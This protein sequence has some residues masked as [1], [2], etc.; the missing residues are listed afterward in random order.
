MSKKDYYELLEIG[1]NASVEEIKKS[2]KRLA[3]KYH[4]DRNPNNKEAEEK[5][6]EIASA[7][8]VLSDSQKR[9]T[10]D[11]YGQESPFGSSQSFHSSGDFSDIFND[12]FSGGFNSTSR[13]K[14]NKNTSAGVPGSDLRYDLEITLEDS[15]KGI[16]APIHY[17]TNIKC[18]V[19]QGIG[20]EGAI[21]PVKCHACK[22]SGMTRA[23]QGFFTIERTCNVCYGEGEIIKNKCKKCDGNGRK[24]A[25]VNI[26]VSIPHGVEEGSKVRVSG[27]GEAGIRNAKSG[28][29]YV[30]VKI[31]PHKIFTRNKADLYCKVPINMTLAILGGEIDVYSI[32]GIHIKVKVPEGIQTNTKL[33]CKEKGMYYINSYTRGDLY[34]QVIVMTVHPKNLNKKQLELL[35]AF[36]EEEKNIG[37][38][39]STEG[40][41]STVKKK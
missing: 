16:Q 30:Y 29:L 27:K 28:D 13:A 33:R 17:V 23:Q 26:S 11:Q 5:F 37:M 20:S 36:S 4:P 21:T 39:C 7:Y 14:A 1:R 41:F 25:E 6:K 3:F 9:A 31:A 22:G 19:C 24:R 38:Q 32:D 18:D 8:E 12:F 2:Y 15:F 34:V 10:Y 40:F 35:Q